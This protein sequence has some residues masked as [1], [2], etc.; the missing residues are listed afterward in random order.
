MKAFAHL[1]RAFAPIALAV[2]GVSAVNAATIA[3]FADPSPNGTQPLFTF[4][5]GGGTGT[6]SGSWTSTG[7]LLETPGLP[8]GD[9]PNAKFIMDPV[10]ATGGPSV[11]T[12][13]AGRI[14][15]QDSG[16][17]DQMFISFS[18]GTLTS[19]VGFGGSDFVGLDVSFSGPIVTSPLSGEA[20]AFSFANPVG[21]PANYTAT[22]AFTSS[23][24]PEPASIALLALGGL[25]ALRRR[26]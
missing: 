6:L 12:L 9:F 20:F 11:W 23:A 1:F 21:T 14:R 4:S 3:T 13:G 24:V 5:S 10:S 16:G 26:S 22:A 17:T 2:A 7:L 25:L 18:G 8:A 19:P 15:F